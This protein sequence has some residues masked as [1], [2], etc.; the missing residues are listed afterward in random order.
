MSDFGSDLALGLVS[1]GISLAIKDWQLRKKWKYAKASAYQQ[2]EWNREDYDYANLHGPSLQR[3]GLEAAGYNPLLAVSSGVDVGSV[4]PTSA[5][6]VPDGDISDVISSAK[7]GSL[8]RSESRKARNE[9]DI[10]ETDKEINKND[11]EVS[12]A[13]RDAA[14]AQAKLDQRKAELSQFALESDEEDMVEVTPHSSR[15][16]S[17]MEKDYIGAQRNAAKR[18]RY[19]NSRGHAIFEDIKDIIHGGA[20]AFS[21]AAQGVKDLRAPRRGRLPTRGR[22]WR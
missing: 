2:H 3:K 5:M 1:G 17:E 18:E 11:L 22:L 14:I 8:I 13:E 16:L 6:Q 12:K 9:A 4:S 19:L 21:N 15:M 7:I 20:S 10:S